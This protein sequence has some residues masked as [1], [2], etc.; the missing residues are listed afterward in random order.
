MVAARALFARQRFACP[1][2][3]RAQCC[4]GRAASTACRTGYSCPRQ[5]RVASP[6]AGHRVYGAAALGSRSLRGPR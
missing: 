5:L 4:C 1:V 3:G 2:L 6:G